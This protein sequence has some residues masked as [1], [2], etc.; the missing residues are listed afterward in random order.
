VGKQEMVF[1]VDV[2]APAAQVWAAVVDWE[3]QGR[4]LPL[5]RVEV[6][7]PGPGGGL[8]TKL[9]ARTGLGRLAVADR[10]T[11][12]EWEPP[13]RARVTK[14]GRVLRGSAWF[15]VRPL[16]EAACRLVWGEALTPP[17]VGPLS[18]PAGL[19][20]GLGTRAFFAVALRRFAR[21]VR[22]GA[23]AGAA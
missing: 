22:A 21:T 8:G 6:V 23:R 9:V 7:E 15:E 2:P 20:L 5:T 3:Q 19:V 1:G 18:R 11:V 14:T 12:T 10:M 17:P 4:W 13:R 16:G